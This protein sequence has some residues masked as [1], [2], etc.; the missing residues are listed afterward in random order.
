MFEGYAAAEGVEFAMSKG[1]DMRM[2]SGKPLHDW[3]EFIWM[4]LAEDAGLLNE[5][6]AA[7]YRLKKEAGEFQ[8]R[9]R[10]GVIDGR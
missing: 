9:K 6:A 8:E 7:T 3:E 2:A 1:Y 5:D 4:I 10:A